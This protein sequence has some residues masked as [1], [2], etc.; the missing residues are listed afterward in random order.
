MPAMNCERRYEMARGKEAE[1]RGKD[2]NRDNRKTGK[3]VERAIKP[4]KDPQPKDG[5][6]GK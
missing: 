3:Q 5:K 1:K 2:T 4:A 6:G